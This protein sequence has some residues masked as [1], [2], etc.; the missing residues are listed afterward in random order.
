[1]LLLERLVVA[2]VSTDVADV[3][4]KEEQP[5]EPSHVLNDAWGVAFLAEPTLDASIKWEVAPGID[6]SE[7]LL[8]L[9]HCECAIAIEPNYWV[10]SIKRAALLAGPQRAM[11][12][13]LIPKPREVLLELAATTHSHQ[14]R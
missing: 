13:L 2:F 14:S 5:V 10:I 6:P 9:D 11:L 8:A 4:P 12:L 3:N 7:V 1:M